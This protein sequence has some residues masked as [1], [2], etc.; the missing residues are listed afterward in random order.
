MELFYSLVNRIFL[1]ELN[2]TGGEVLLDKSSHHVAYCAQAPCELFSAIYLF[3]EAKYLKKGLEHATIR[4]NIIFK[5]DRGF[6]KARYQEVL[7]ACAL[8]KDLAMFEAGDMT[9]EISLTMTRIS[10]ALTNLQKL[11]KKV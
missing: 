11:E 2:C 4:D 8:T 7:E 10:Q 9:G 6:D 3:A 5:S 1:I